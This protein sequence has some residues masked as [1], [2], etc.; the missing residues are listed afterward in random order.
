MLK[1]GVCKTLL[2][3]LNKGAK[4]GDRTVQL[5]PHM[6]EGLASTVC[7]TQQDIDTTADGIHYASRK[8]LSNGSPEQTTIAPDHSANILRR[9]TEANH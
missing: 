9:G 6:P 3:T 4:E 7:V 1:T 8:R 2:N 5:Q